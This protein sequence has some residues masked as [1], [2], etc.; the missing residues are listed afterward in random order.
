M[1]R[2]QVKG[3]ADQAK[4]KVKEAAADL[5]GNTRLQGEGKADQLKGRAQ[6]GMG[7]AKQKV[8]RTIDKA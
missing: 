4:G 2:D 6:A 3:R 7:D 1:N 5:S 8:K